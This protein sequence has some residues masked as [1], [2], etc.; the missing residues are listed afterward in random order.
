MCEQQSTLFNDTDNAE[1]LRDHGM[2]TAK[3]HADAYSREWSDQAF[4]YLLEFPATHGQTFMAEDVRKYAEMRGLPNPPSKRAWGGI[5]V[6]ARTAGII[7][8]AGYGLTSNPKAH[9]TPARLWVK[10]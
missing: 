3:N 5:M 4:T 1:D 10:I 7:K 2:N 6:R 9:K 8:A